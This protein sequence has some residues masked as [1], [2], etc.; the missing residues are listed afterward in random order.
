MKTNIILKSKDRDLFG[1]TIRQN[2]KEQFLSVTDL[3]KA[4]ETARWQHGW[5]EKKINDVLSWNATK[6]RIYYLLKEANLIKT[7]LNLFM[8]MVEK[9]GITSVLKG[10]NVYKTTGKGANK[11]V[12][13][14]PYIWML[15]AMELNPMIYAKVVIWLSDSLIFDRIEA[16]SEYKPMNEAIK[17]VTPNPDY[18]KYAKMINEKV[19]GNHI[20]GMRNLASANELRKITKIEQFITQGISIGMIT[21]KEG[22][23]NETNLQ[24][25]FTNNIEIVQNEFLFSYL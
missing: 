3:Q 1:I 22:K 15:L 24:V 4:Y 6:E 12:M 7:S 5:S 11:Q 16:G 25:K 13:A 18:S 17:K 8:E 2:T 21:I 10:L 14:N 9:E 20:T 23:I 19:F